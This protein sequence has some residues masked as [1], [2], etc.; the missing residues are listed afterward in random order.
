MT[1]RYNNKVILKRNKNYKLFN[2]YY[3]I[4]DHKVQF[5]ICFKLEMNK[6]LKLGENCSN[7]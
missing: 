3:L 6:C 5:I 7:H 1:K 2:S 4:K